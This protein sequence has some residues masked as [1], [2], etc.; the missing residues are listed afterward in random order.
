M[1]IS[2]TKFFLMAGS[3]LAAAAAASGQ[4]VSYTTNTITFGYTNRAA[5]LADGWSFIATESDGTTRNTEITNPAAGEVIVYD[6]P[7]NPRVLR[8]PVDIGN[9]L[10]TP[11][12]SRNALFHNLPTN[13]IS[14]QLQ[15][16]FN[17]T[18]S[19][20]EV[21]LMLYQDDDDFVW[22]G[23]SYSGNE[24]MRFGREFTGE[25][26][27]N[28]YTV[29]VLNTPVTNSILRLDRDPVTD[30]ISGLYSLDGG[31]TW[32]T[33]DNFSQCFKNPCL[34]IWAGNAATSPSNFPNCDLY[35]LKIITQNTPVPPALVV[36][37]LHLVFNCIA[38]QPCTNIQA[39]D[40]VLQTWQDSPVQW[41][42]T[43]SSPSWLLTSTN[44]GNTPA[45]SLSST[46]IGLTP[47]SSCDVSVNATGLSPGIYQGVLGF[48]AP[49]ATSAV[50]NVTLIVNTNSRVNLAT[51]Q[52]GKSGAMSVSVDDA[53]MTDFDT[54][55]TNGLYGSYMIWEVFTS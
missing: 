44:T 40:V 54:L 17:P 36:R 38:G 19:Y 43:N 23:H 7:D 30:R 16:S 42:L 31:N 48:S 8:I 29:N 39:L 24:R 49:G 14:M 20:Q 13:W 12:T 51:W 18:T 26:L 1:K 27:E 47:T 6:P 15:Q 4:P 2:L 5:L 55:S 53:Y 46:N 50:A 41:T 22:M 37:P 11:N 34:S 25:L 28:V 3:L 35:Q 9:L 10:L 33:V 21:N 32:V 45:W 52:G